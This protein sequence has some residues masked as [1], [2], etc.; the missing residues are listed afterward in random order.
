MAAIAEGVETAE[1]AEALRVM[2]CPLVQGYH[3]SPAVT[4]VAI[5]R[6]LAAER[7]PVR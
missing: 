3:Y 2:Q 6:R 5:D 1:Q 4:S 7:S